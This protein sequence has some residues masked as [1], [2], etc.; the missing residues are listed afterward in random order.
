L[1]ATFTGTS[2]SVYAPKES[3]AGKIDIQIDGQT[4]TTAD[5]AATGARQ[6]QQMVGQATGLTSGQHTLSIV[7]RG[8]GPVSVD[9]IVVQ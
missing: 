2:V 4:S 7:N 9:A 8:P 6:A 5:L 3:G 1:T